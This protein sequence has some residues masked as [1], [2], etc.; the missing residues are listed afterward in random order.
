VTLPR[1]IGADPL[2]YAIGA[3]VW[4]FLLY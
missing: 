4:R 3:T 2:Q 1:I